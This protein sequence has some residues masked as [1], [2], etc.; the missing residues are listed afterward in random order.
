VWGEV[1]STLWGEGNSSFTPSSPLDLS[2]SLDLSSPLEHVVE[3][4]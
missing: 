3:R 4:V 1:T 2:P